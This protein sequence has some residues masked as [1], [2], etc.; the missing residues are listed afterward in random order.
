MLQL[1]FHANSVSRF[2]LP[3]YSK[4]KHPGDRLGFTM[5]PEKNFWK[6]HKFYENTLSVANLFKAE[7]FG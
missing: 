6:E 7:A 4:Q 2:P 1:D 5:L 3:I